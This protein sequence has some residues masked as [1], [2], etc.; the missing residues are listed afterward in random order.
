MCSKIS[1]MIQGLTTPYNM[2]LKLIPILQYMHHDSS[3]ASMVRKLLIDLIS[4]YSSTDFV[5]VTLHCLTK[6]AAATLTDIP[7]Q[8]S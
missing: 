5:I 4:E 7:N 6:L 2:K 8:V 1:N 3:T